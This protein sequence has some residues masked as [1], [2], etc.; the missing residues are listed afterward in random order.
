[1]EAKGFRFRHGIKD[2]GVVKYAMAAA[3]DKILL[4][5]FQPLETIPA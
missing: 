3:P 1:M 5:L 4:E 2:F